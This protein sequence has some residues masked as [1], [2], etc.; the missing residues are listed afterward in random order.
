MIAKNLLVFWKRCV[1]G[2]LHIERRCEQRIFVFTGKVVLV[3][4]RQ[5]TGIAVWKGLGM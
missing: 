3:F 1:N 4:L 2:A 5:F